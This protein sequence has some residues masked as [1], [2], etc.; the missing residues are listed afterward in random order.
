MIILIYPILSVI[1]QEIIFRVL[2]FERYSCI[3][4]QKILSLV[5]NSVIFAYAHLV[6]NNP[7]A[8]IITLLTSPIFA[9]A[10]LKKS[11]Y[12]C[13]LVHSFG[14]QIVFTYGLGKYF[15]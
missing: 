1:P 11:F 7:H 4:N 9:Y 14:G 6:F 8:V 2:F 12:T 3:F 5:I 10:Y 13:L 15:F